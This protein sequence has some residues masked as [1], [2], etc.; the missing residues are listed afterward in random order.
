[1]HFRSS[2][3][4]K[5]PIFIVKNNR[6]RHPQTKKNFSLVCPI[7]KKIVHRQEVDGERTK[8]TRNLSWNEGDSKQM[9]NLVVLS[10]AEIASF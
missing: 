7:F 8:T 1:M 5:E 4:Y 6:L 10:K 2:S 3:V 9:H